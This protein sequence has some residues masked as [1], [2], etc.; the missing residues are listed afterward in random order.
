MSI[1]LHK[2]SKC[3]CLE[4]FLSFYCCQHFS[5]ELLEKAEYLYEGSIELYA[6]DDKFEVC[7]YLM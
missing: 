2:I 7:I 4:H 6:E 1:V 3:C 5:E